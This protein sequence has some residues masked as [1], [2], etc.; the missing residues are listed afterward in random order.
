MLRAISSLPLFLSPFYSFSCLSMSMCIDF[1]EL[2][3]QLL[4][5]LVCRNL[6]WAMTAAAAESAAN[7]ASQAAAAL[8][9]GTYARSSSFVSPSSM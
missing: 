3:S 1:C 6:A 4:R 7:T 8:A 9:E 5:L 2:T